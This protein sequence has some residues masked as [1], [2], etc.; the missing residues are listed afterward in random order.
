M[1]TMGSGWFDAMGSGWQD[2]AAGASSG[3][4]SPQTFAM[5]ADRPLAEQRVPSNFTVQFPAK[6]WDG[7]LRALTFLPEFFAS[8]DKAG[9]TWK[10][11]ITI[12]PP[13]Q[14]VQ[15]GAGDSIDDLLM[16]AVTERPEAMG[17]ILNQAQNQQLCFLQM[18]MINRNSHPATYYL[19]K[20][21]ARVGEVVMTSLKLH[22]NRARPSQICPTLYPPVPVPGHPA[23]PAGHALIATLTASC[24]IEATAGKA[25]AK[26]P[27]EDALNELAAV[28]GRN[29]VIAGLHFRSDIAAGN[30]AGAK[31]HAFLQDMETYQKAVT[32]AQAE[33]ASAP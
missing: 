24:L 18:L 26:S 1:S 29:R 28:I 4:G 8:K 6:Y 31:T 10:E 12:E 17:E 3:G 19:T 21:A 13:P 14:V 5:R 15:S 7:D 27:Y 25:G 33:W 16:L 30:E 22:F 20:L 11:A 32:G 2:P 9:R 23:Y